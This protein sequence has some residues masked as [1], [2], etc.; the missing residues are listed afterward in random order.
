MIWQYPDIISNDLVLLSVLVISK[1]CTRS[2]SNFRGSWS[3]LYLPPHFIFFSFLTLVFLL[4]NLELV[5]LQPTNP[6]TFHSPLTPSIPSLLPSLAWNPWF[7]VTIPLYTELLL[8]YLFLCQTH[9]ETLT[10]VEPNLPLALDCIWEVDCD[11]RNTR[12]SWLHGKNKKGGPLA[13]AGNSAAFL[14]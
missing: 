7:I 9:L 4:H 8:P 2:K 12:P 13:L 1:N 11:N 14:S 10:V 3:L 5:N 6:I